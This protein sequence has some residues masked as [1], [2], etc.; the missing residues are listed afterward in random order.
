MFNLE[1][2]FVSLP[3][4]GGGMSLGARSGADM[5]SISSSST[6]G[7][8]TFLAEYSWSNPGAFKTNEN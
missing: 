4:I 6:S 1:C 2:F 7:A 5:T 3:G 8:W